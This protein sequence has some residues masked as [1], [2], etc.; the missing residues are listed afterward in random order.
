MKNACMLDNFI[1]SIVGGSPFCVGASGPIAPRVWHRGPGHETWKWGK[2]ICRLLRYSGAQDI[3]QLLANAVFSYLV[4][5]VRRES[6][7]YSV[8]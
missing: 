3:K 1:R 7:R 5:L 2:P 8:Y 6:A 4:V